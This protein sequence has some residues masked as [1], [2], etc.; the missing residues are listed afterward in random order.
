MEADSLKTGRDKPVLRRFVLRLVVGRASVEAD[1]V[2]ADGGDIEL[3]DA[4]SF[5]ELLDL[6]GEFVTQAS[7]FASQL[8]PQAT[9]FRPKL[10]SQFCSHRIHLVAKA[11][12]VVAEL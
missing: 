11:M 5:V 10:L 8:L 7:N 1:E 9:D 2:G 3:H 4:K 12:D 6:R